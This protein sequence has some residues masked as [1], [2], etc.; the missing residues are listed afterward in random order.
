[1]LKVLYFLKMSIC[2]NFTAS[3]IKQH[4]TFP[5]KITFTFI[6]IDTSIKLHKNVRVIY[7]NKFHN[8]A[9]YNKRGNTVSK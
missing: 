7:L 3:S 6:V 4:I 8:E 5:N 2:T 9:R 1:M